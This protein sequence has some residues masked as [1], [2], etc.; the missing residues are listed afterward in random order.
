MSQMSS[1]SLTEEFFLI[2]A[3]K[4]SVMYLDLMFITFLCY[5]LFSC[6]SWPLVG[7]LLRGGAGVCIV[8]F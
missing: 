3:T 4:F 1:Q 5:H 2:G 6:L 8:Q 7:K